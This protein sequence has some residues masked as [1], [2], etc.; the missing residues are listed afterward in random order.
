MNQTTPKAPPEGQIAAEESLNITPATNTAADSPTAESVSFCE[1]LAKARCVTDLKKVPY[2]ADVSG[3]LPHLNDGAPLGKYR[4]DR[5]FLL[6]FQPVCVDR[7]NT[8]LP[9]AALGLE[10]S[11]LL[12]NA[13]ICT[14]GQRQGVRLL[15][16]TEDIGKPEH[17]HITT[18]PI[19]GNLTLSKKAR[20]KARRKRRKAGDP[21]PL[22]DANEGASSSRAEQ[23]EQPRQ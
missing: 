10:P 9:L 20:A 12:N 19:Q 18:G 4:Y 17:Q 8:V 14:R 7:P 3:P 22:D 1:A 2:P 13:A 5:N 11:W 6:Q 23:H 21:S 15:E 16:R